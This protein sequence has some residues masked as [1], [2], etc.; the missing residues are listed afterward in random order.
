MSVAAAPVIA[1]IGAGLG[2]ASSIASTAYTMSKGRPAQT[3]NLE[4]SLGGLLNLMPQGGETPNFD[5]GYNMGNLAD[6]FSQYKNPA[7]INNLMPAGGDLNQYLPTAQQPMFRPPSL[8]GQVE[9][10]GFSSP[11][12]D[13]PGFNINSLGGM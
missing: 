6:K 2:A 12:F 7:L 11:K 9:G 4:N 5:N 3:I 13:N 1:A 10:L 8:S